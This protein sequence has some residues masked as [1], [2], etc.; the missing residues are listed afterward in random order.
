MLHTWELPGPFIT[1]KQQHLRSL[2]F[3]PPLY[4]SYFLLRWTAFQEHI[5]A[6]YI[7]SQLICLVIDT[8]PAGCCGP[9]RSVCSL[10][11]SSQSRHQRSRWRSTPPALRRGRRTGSQQTGPPSR[12]Q[13]QRATASTNRRALNFNRWKKTLS[14]FLLPTC[15]IRK[16]NRNPTNISRNDYPPQNVAK[17]SKVCFVCF[18]F[19]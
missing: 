3:W 18:E 16:L 15:T 6:V 19:L 11:R 13:S 5:Q 1:F 14:S 12:R 17:Q 2:F 10:S 4:F 7:S 9:T 8:N